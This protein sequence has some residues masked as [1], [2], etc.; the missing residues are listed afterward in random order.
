MR[1]VISDSQMTCVSSFLECRLH[2]GVPAP[3]GHQGP[4]LAARRSLRTGDQ[5]VS[6]IPAIC[7]SECH[8]WGKKWAPSYTK[9][10]D[11][12]KTSGAPIHLTP[13]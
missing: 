6:K 1:V 10:E 12:T 8:F 9:R 13:A 3:K 11:R 2:T 5:V 4:G 7:L